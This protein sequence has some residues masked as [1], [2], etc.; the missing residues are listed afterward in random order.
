MKDAG[1][2]AQNLR[3]QTTSATSIS[4]MVDDF[5]KWEPWKTIRTGEKSA[6]RCSAYDENKIIRTGELFG[7]SSPTTPIMEFKSL[8]EA[9]ACLKEW[10][11]RLYLNDWIIKIELNSRHAPASDCLARIHTTHEMK[12]ADIYFADAS[13]EVKAEQLV[14]YCA[15]KILVHEM[16]HIVFDMCA[17]ENKSLEDAEFHMNQHIKTE[18]MAR[19]LIMAKYNLDPS[20]FRNV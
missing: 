6:I 11:E 1:D 19:S 14:K 9:N 4:D 8:E 7:V 13:D 16:L 17:R 5:D 3:K 10:Q 2:S 15:E 12:M 18:F 20:F